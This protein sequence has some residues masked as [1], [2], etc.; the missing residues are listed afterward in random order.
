MQNTPHEAG[1][2]ERAIYNSINMASE[3]DELDAVAETDI[4]SSIVLGFNPME[5]GVEG[6]IGHLGRWWKCS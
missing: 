3:A 2:A 5:P 4:S 6:K 1:L